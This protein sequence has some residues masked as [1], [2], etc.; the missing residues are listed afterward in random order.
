MKIITDFSIP[1]LSRKV[2]QQF[3]IPNPSE[4]DILRIVDDVRHRFSNKF[5]KD[6]LHGKKPD[7]EEVFAYGTF[8]RK[9]GSFIDY[10]VD[11]V[12]AMDC[13]GDEF[14]LLGA[15]GDKILFYWGDDY[16]EGQSYPEAVRDG[17][18]I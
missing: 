4:K 17:Y 3:N 8:H 9:D 2:E 1:T 11:V 5:Q 10:R 6:A 16:G 15:N 7:F 12:G 14:Y 13:G 18:E